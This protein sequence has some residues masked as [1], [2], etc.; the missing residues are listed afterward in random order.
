[1][2]TQG[3]IGNIPVFPYL[4]VILV[5][6]PQ[7]AGC[8]EKGIPVRLRSSARYCNPISGNGACFLPILLAIVL[9]FRMRRPQKVG[10]AR[11]PAKMNE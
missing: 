3:N 9:L 7:I 2:T 1:M 10:K 6:T 4:A 5:C 11:R 8:N